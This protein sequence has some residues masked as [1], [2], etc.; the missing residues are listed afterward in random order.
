MGRGIAER[1]AR[2]VE[3]ASCQFAKALA[4]AFYLSPLS[5]LLLYVFRLGLL[6]SILLE[7]P[8][9]IALEKRFR[10]WGPGVDHLIETAWR[11]T[12]PG[13]KA[14]LV[15][16]LSTSPLGALVLLDYGLGRIVRWS[17]STR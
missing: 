5:F 6:V 8:L 4:S 1:A 11:S 17:C 9:F 10:P 3:S 14:L 7:L 13:G 12:G 15:A 2:G 16:L